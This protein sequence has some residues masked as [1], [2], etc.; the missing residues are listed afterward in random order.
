MPSPLIAFAAILVAVPVLD[1]V[2]LGL[3]MN[4]FYLRELSELGR[5]VDGK[6]QPLYPPI[7]VIYLAL[8]AGVF[9]FAV[10]PASTAS[11]AGARGALLGFVVY[12]VYE[13]TNYSLLKNWPLKLVVVDSLWGCVI[14]GLSALAG[15][16]ALTLAK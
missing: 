10:R 1:L 9:A 16:Y 8:A 12:A 11:D 4:R 7:A 6:W 3:I 5:I 2:W 13:C 15:F 14:C